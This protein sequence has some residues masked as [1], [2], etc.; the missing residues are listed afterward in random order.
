MTN[1]YTWAKGLNFS[2]DTGGL[3][4]D[5]IRGAFMTNKGRMNQDRRHVWVSSYTYELPFGKNKPFLQTG[6]GRWVLGDWQ[7]QGI[8]SIMSGEPFT[9][10]APGST[11]N[12]GGNQQRADVV[13]TP[14]RIGEIAGPSGDAL[15]FTTNAFAIPKQDTLGNAGREIFDGPGLF[16]WDFSVFRRFPVP[17]LG[18]Q[19][20]ITFR[21][22]SFNFTNTPHFNNPNG[23]VSNR[24]FGRVQTATSDQRQFQF[25]LTLRF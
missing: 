9:I 19:A 3:S 22:E 23:D 5:G 11:L 4:V 18:E 16:N 6:P 10:T 2:D 13:G 15:W 20:A 12:A 21:L 1:A 24:N 14:E 8:V 17:Q 25:G 7:L